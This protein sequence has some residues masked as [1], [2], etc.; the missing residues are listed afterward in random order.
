[1]RL[2]ETT[3]NKCGA[4]L[5]IDLDNLQAYC[6]HCGSKLQIDIDN[7]DQLLLSKEKTE[8]EKIKLL[9][10]KNYLDY[11]KFKAKN[12][13]KKQKEKRDLILVIISILLSVLFLGTMFALDILNII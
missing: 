11:E 10:D 4:T 8:R 13:Y 2:I 1:M 3:C 7:L 6:Q 12:E 5:E 9:R